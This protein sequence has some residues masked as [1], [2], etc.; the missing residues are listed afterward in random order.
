MATAVVVATPEQARALF[1]VLHPLHGWGTLGAL[2]EAFD[3]RFRG[4]RLRALSALRAGFLASLGRRELP[5]NERRAWRLAVVFLM[6]HAY[7]GHT[8][9]ANPFLP[10]VLAAAFMDQTD[11]HGDRRFDLDNL[12]SDDDSDDSDYREYSAEPVPERRSAEEKAAERE[13]R[14]REKEREEQER[15]EK[16]ERE[17]TVADDRDTKFEHAARL[18]IYAYY[19]D[20]GRD[21]GSDG[22]DNCGGAARRRRAVMPAAVAHV[23]IDDDME[24]ALGAAV[25]FESLPRGAASGHPV[26]DLASLMDML[27]SGG[28][29]W[30]AFRRAVD[31]ERDEMKYFL[32]HR[33]R[34]AL[35]ALEDDEMDEGED[36]DDFELDG[37]SERIVRDVL[38]SPGYHIRG[39]L[40]HE[41]RRTKKMERQVARALSDAV[42][43]PLMP[44]TQQFV[45]EKLLARHSLLVRLPPLRLACAHPA[46]LC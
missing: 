30:H 33:Y 34:H 21:G 32:R 10:F 1:R 42:S 3:A 12:E 8:A 44:S 31:S 41:E 24:A 9:A 22:R 18:L 38:L 7:R 28:P 11:R 29:E 37:V 27:E 35:D 43:G 40:F 4:C 17:K 36:E 46:S 15:Q 14:R 5:R 25:R 16:Q 13:A 20:G 23:Q 2:G 19:S 45:A 26:E 6:L 39:W